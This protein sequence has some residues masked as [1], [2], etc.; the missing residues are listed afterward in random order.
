MFPAMKLR[1]VKKFGM[2][3]ERRGLFFCLNESVV[4]RRTGKKV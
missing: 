4:K 3:I 2:R 1:I